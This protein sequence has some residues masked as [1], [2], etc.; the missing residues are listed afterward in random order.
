LKGEAKEETPEAE[1]PVEPEPVVVEPALIVKPVAE[2]PMPEKAAEE[3]KTEPIQ[4]KAAVKKP[5]IGKEDVRADAADHN[6]LGG[7]LNRTPLQ[8]LRSGIPLNEKFG[9]IRTLFKGNAS[10]F[11]DAVLKLNN[12]ANANEMK[13]YLRLLE[14]RFGWDVESEAYQSFYVYIERKML[15]LQT[16]NA[17]SDQ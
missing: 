15:T 12:A 7:Q 9:M 14:Q 8:D 13:H 17:N 16:S 5:M 1:K 10:D 2:K 3:P 11:G 4:E 6:T